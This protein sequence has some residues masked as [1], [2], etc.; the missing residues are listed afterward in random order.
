M[1]KCLV[2]VAGRPLIHYAFSSLADVGVRR[3]VVV[4]GYKQKQLA[5]ALGDGSQFGLEIEYASN[6]RFWRGNA[7]SLA[8]A[9][10]T[11]NGPFILTMADHIVSPELF[12]T[13]LYAADGSNAIAIDRSV[14]TPER[15]TEA[16]KVATERGLVT[17]IGKAL[18]D[19]DG[20][21]TGVS[22]WNDR[23]LIEAGESGATGELA[24]L[25]TRVSSHHPV[26][27]VD[28]TGSFWL[29]VDTPEDLREA[30]LSLGA[31][32]GLVV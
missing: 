4:V 1:P 15:L 19:W 32:A 31:D 8:R 29:D 23:L 13:L 6:P 16:T 22:L 2:Q 5:A 26:L 27:A 28:V 9:L 7:S 20:A 10:E 21:D 14:L 30:E 17:A 3:V 25:M 18:T 24:A 12:R 11:V